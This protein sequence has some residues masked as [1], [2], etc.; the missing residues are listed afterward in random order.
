M[1]TSPRWT[2]VWMPFVTA[3]SAWCSALAACVPDAWGG[4]GDSALLE[5][6]PGREQNLRAISQMCPFCDA[7]I[8]TTDRSSRD[9][10]ASDQCFE[11]VFAGA[12]ATVRLGITVAV[13]HVLR[14]QSCVF[15]DEP[16]D[17]LQVNG[18]DRVIAYLTAL[19]PGMPMWYK[20]AET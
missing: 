15:A 14:K 11:R 9:G 7:N 10:D 18:R 20:I 2:G 19:M 6:V 13:V 4:A 8:N 1:P 3:I 17:H 5:P 12:A 16:R